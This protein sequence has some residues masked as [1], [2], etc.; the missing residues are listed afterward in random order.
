[1]PSIASLNGITVNGSSKGMS[2]IMHSVVT[3]HLVENSGCRKVLSVAIL[4]RIQAC[5]LPLVSKNR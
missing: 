4:Q 5:F 1:M 3:H 2:E